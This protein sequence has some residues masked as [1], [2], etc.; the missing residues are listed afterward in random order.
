MEISDIES[1]DDDPEERTR[2]IEQMAAAMNVMNNESSFKRGELNMDI[3]TLS[4]RSEEESDREQRQPKQRSR[5]QSGRK[6]SM[7]RERNVAKIRYCWRCH[8]AGHENWQCREDVQ[9]GGWCPRCLETSHWEDQCWVSATSVT[10]PVCSLPG[11]LPCIHQASDFR[12]RKLVI[13]TFGWLPFK[14]WFQ[15]LTF[16]SWWNCSG[17]TGVPLYKILQRNTEQDLDLGFEES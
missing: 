6:R 8:Q 14:D 2:R 15:D 17:Y 13:D 7:S 12:Q 10:C 11:H 4:E 5:R 16:R 1:E 9:P 3:D